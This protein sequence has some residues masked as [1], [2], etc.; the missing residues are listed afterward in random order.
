MF[1]EG[2]V[3][4]SFTYLSPSLRVYITPVLYVEASNFH[5]CEDNRIAIFVLY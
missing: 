1:L 3:S 5:A 2:Y 4:S